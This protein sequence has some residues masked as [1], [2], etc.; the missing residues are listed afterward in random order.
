MGLLLTPLT[1]TTEGV[2][3]ATTVPKFTQWFSAATVYMQNILASSKLG[4]NALP[5]APY[6]PLN[7]RVFGV[8]K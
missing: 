6:T 4:F 2:E 7:C 3:S 1:A 8:A 5:G